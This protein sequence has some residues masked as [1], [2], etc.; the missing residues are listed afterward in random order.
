MARKKKEIVV[1]EN[2]TP[3][4]ETILKPTEAEKLEALKQ[5]LLASLDSTEFALPFFSEVM[6]NMLVEE[7]KLVNVPE[8]ERGSKYYSLPSIMPYDAEEKKRGFSGKRGRMFYSLC[9]GKDSEFVKDL[10][11]FNRKKEGNNRLEPLLYRRTLAAMAKGY[12][13]TIHKD[14]KTLYPIVHFKPAKAVETPAE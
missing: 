1:E 4:V 3:I 6:Y 10:E 12:F 7:G 13:P 2:P 5:R 14:F 9:L 11:T 8:K